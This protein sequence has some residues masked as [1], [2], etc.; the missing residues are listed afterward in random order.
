M[1]P[2]ITTFS[3]KVICPLDLKP[4][5]VCIEDIAKSLSNQCRFGGHIDEFYSTAEHSVNCWKASKI[6]TT[7]SFTQIKCL[8]HDGCESFTTIDHVKPCKANYAVALPPNGEIITIDE[9]ERRITKTMVDGLGFP[10][11]LDFTD[12]YI[13]Y[14]DKC[15]LNTESIAL[16]GYK[17][18]DEYPVLNMSIECWTP[19]VAYEN[20]LA[21]Y[22]EA[23]ER[24]TKC[25]D[26]V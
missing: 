15:M 7:N 12:T 24:V 22:K 25:Y 18:L 11:G 3:G 20:F 13:K 5:D 23:K 21:A 2:I 9:L 6:F 17:V 16:R 10:S 26:G 1:K 19:K 4:G 14:V 8:L